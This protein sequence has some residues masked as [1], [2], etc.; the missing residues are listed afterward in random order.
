MLRIETNSSLRQGRRGRQDKRRGAAATELAI[1]LPIIVLLIFASIECC[2]MLFVDEALHVACYESLRVAIQKDGVAGDAVVR[3]EEVLEQF[4]I[5]EGAITFE[6]A[7]LST[8]DG[9]D[10]IVVEVEAPC[11]ANSVMPAWF[12]GG[13][14]LR[15]R[16]A[17]ARE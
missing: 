12:F 16:C 5:E 11:D 15:A 8:T 3:G 14:T 1:C 10:T 6:P 13:A 9:G 2:S 4:G 7:D 17:M